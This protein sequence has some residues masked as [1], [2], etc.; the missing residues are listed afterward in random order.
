MRDYSRKMERL[1]CLFGL[2]YVKEKCFNG[3]KKKVMR[4][5]HS[6]KQSSKII[7]SSSHEIIWNAKKL[8]RGDYNNVSEIVKRLKKRV[9]KKCR[10]QF[11]MQL[12]SPFCLNHS[13]V[14]HTKRNWDSIVAAGYGLSMS[15][16]SNTSQSPLVF[17]SCF[18]SQSHS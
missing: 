8:Q 2:I 12:F 10:A 1:T 3:N 16:T 9:S 6:Y 5:K 18:H 4:S 14:I 7:Q 17:F 13:A 15:Y 11:L